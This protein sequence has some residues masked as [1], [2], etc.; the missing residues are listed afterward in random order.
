VNESTFSPPPDGGTTSAVPAAGGLSFD[1][2]A[3]LRQSA[4]TAWER[5]T[6]LE[7]VV[8][9]L[10]DRNRALQDA[11]DASRRKPV[12]VTI[13]AD[14]LEER[15]EEALARH[16]VRFQGMRPADARAAVAEGKRIM[17]AWGR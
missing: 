5:V 16:L 9:D 17:A 3:F 2:L 13:G 6:E 11:L 8:A 15:S 4:V 12:F 1:D 10:R 14:E 7:I